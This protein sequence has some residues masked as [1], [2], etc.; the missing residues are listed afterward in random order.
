[1]HR[2]R[3]KRII[4]EAFRK[5]C[6]KLPAVDIIVVAQPASSAMS[7]DRLSAALEDIWRQLLDD[8]RPEIPAD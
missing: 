6:G 2:N 4:R 3:I 5:N 8:Y 1:V 7:N